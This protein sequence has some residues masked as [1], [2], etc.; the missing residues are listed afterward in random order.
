M[1]PDSSVTTWI[2]QVKLGDDEAARK[3]WQKYHSA[4]LELA[5]KLLRFARRREADEEDVVQ[6]VFDAFFRAAHEGQLTQ[7]NDRED[8]WK[9]ISK[10]TENRVRDQRRRQ[11]RLKRG[12]GKVRGESALLAPDDSAARRGIE[13]V[14]DSRPTSDALDA[15]L[16]ELCGMFEQLGE[17]LVAETI[18]LRAD[19]WSHEQIARKLDISVPTVRRKLRLM[20]ARLDRELA[21]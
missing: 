15:L 4:L 10:I 3:L 13:Q 9:L 2:A 19:G 21:E 7:L 20:E 14:A 16:E 5:R 17:P 6:E 1:T 18:A 12:Q 8:F 11:R